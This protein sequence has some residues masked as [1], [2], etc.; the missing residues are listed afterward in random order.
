MKN[1]CYAPEQF[2]L[3]SETVDAKF[4]SFSIKDNSSIESGADHVVKKF[5]INVID[6]PGMIHLQNIKWVLF[7]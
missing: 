1:P 5:T 7:F 6:T 4:Q 3:F 2:S